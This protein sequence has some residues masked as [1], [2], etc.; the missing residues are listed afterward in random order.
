MNPGGTAFL[1]WPGRSRHGPVGLSSDPLPS[2]STGGFRDEQTATMNSPI[3]IVLVAS[4]IVKAPGCNGYAFA[5]GSE[6]V[7]NFR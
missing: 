6:S 5:S 7:L 4:L 2:C 1:Q 3:I